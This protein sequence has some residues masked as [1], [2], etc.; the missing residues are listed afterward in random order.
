MMAGAV[1]EQTRCACLFADC[2]CDGIY[3][4]YTIATAVPHKA[5][6][7]PRPPPVSTPRQGREVPAS[8]SLQAES[9]VLAGLLGDLELGELLDE[10]RVAVAG[11]DFLQRREVVVE[12]VTV[13]AAEVLAV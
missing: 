10:S 4:V 7:A 3:G 12:L 9:L 5:A 6:H 13:A 2:V 11:A 8:A 1:A